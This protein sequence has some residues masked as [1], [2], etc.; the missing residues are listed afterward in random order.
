MS[1]TYAYL[2]V[3]VGTV[4][5]YFLVSLILFEHART[6][7]NDVIQGVLIG[8]GLAFVTAQVYARVKA[9]KVNGW[10]TMY[11]LGEP[12]NNMF[13]R[14]AQAQLFPGPVNVPQ[15]AMY[16]WTNADGAGRT[17]SGRHDHIVRFPPGGLPPSQA[18]WS[19]TMADAK[20]HFVANPIDRYSVSDRSGLVANADGS[21]DIYVQ[22]AAPPGHGSNWLPAPAGSF[23]LWLR[24]YMP[25]RAILDGTWKAPPVV[26]AK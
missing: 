24:V 4:C 8:A 17:L 16:W 18:F 5:A 11:G 22:N 1:R 19:L 2:A 13:L 12:G 3:L 10:I 26:E 25:G 20:N 15:E 21:V 23:L 9:T 7:R 6:L 14:A